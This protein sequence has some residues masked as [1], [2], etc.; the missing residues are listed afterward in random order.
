MEAFDNASTRDYERLMTELSICNFMANRI[1]TISN[2]S[3]VTAS[4]RCRGNVFTEPLPRNGL[5]RVYSLP[6]QRVYRTV[7]QQGL[8]SVFLAYSPYFEKIKMMVHEINLCVP[9]PTPESRNSGAGRDN[10]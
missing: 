2:S 6:R 10:R 9:P 3:Y 8:C 4:I 5:F 1:D 7:A